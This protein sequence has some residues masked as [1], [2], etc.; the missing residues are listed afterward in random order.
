MTGRTRAFLNID[1]ALE[2]PEAPTPAQ[3][4]NHGKRKPCREP[5]PNLRERFRQ[6]RCLR[7]SAKLICPRTAQ[8]VACLSSANLFHPYM[9]FLVGDGS[10]DFEHPA[11][12]YSHDTR[13]MYI[14]GVGADARFYKSLWLRVNYEYQFWPDFFHHHALTS[15]GVDIGVAY[16]FGRF[17]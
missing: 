9:K 3:A 10:I 14:P 1:P 15:S 4:L 16:D 7:N 13:T 17:R 5:I 8:P 12:N 2:A 11:P 6:A